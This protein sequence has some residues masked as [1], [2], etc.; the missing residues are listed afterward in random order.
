MRVKWLIMPCKVPPRTDEPITPADIQKL[1]TGPRGLAEFWWDVTRAVDFRESLVLDR[2]LTL[3]FD[4]TGY[5]GGADYG[6]DRD[7]LKAAALTAARDAGVSIDEDGYILLYLS[8]AF[9]TFGSL[10]R[11][12]VA[13]GSEQ[14]VHAHEMGH[15]IGLNHTF[16]G[17]SPPTLSL[18]GPTSGQNP[19]LAPPNLMHVA[20]Y[21]DYAD[22]MSALTPWDK[23]GRGP[24]LCG[25]LLRDLDGI[26]DDHIVKIDDASRFVPVTLAPLTEWDSS[27]PRLVRLQVHRPAAGMNGPER[28]GIYNYFIE[29]RLASGWDSGLPSA[30]VLIHELRPVP[31]ADS[32]NP[33][34]RLKARIVRLCRAR[35]GLY[36]SPLAE[37]ERF[38]D[39]DR[40]FAVQ[41]ERIDLS[42]K[43]AVIA[44]QVGYQWS[45]A[46]RFR[47]VQ[48]WATQ[49]GYVGGFPNFHQANYGIRYGTLMIKSSAAAWRDIPAV[50][51]GNP[52][53][54]EGRFRAVNDWAARNG[55]VSGFP[56][57]HEA[58]HGSGTVYGTILLKPGFAQWRDVPIGALHNPTSV[59]ARFRA[60]NDWANA[61]GYTSGFPNFHEADYRS[62]PVLLLKS[63]VADWRDIP[64]V[65]LGNPTSVEARFR[66]VNDWAARN[67]YLSAFPNFYDADY[68][69]GTV[70][71]TLL[72]KSSAAEWR[73]IPVAELGNPTS[74]EARFRAV[75]DWATRNGYVSGFPN[76]H[77]ANY[78]SGTVYGAILL[79]RG[80]ADWRDIRASE[81]Y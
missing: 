22:V 26:S 6:V 63:D 81:L 23:G 64:A 21:G 46:E 34:P 72:I 73:D 25:P 5:R 32:D 15:G 66:A 37:G 31:E 28:P 54:V 8:D 43:E 67:G 55:Y 77:E 52:A 74:V 61:R 12:V 60:L 76:F 24:G 3:D 80:S 69:S 2:W 10:K 41:V 30:G 48:D 59:E 19:A 53:S 58:D 7:R 39:P 68:G 18:D 33:D 57:F 14:I 29:F 17:F 9:D 49:H 38:V 71:G 40:G 20:E 16:G 65:E 13:H 78:G 62:F 1:F 11:V 4:R 51:L 50:E 47:A 42:R 27:L 70:Y 75:N 36:D 35:R 45:L 44:V 79:K 56:N